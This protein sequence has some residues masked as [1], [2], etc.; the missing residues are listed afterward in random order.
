MTKVKKATPKNA[1]KIEAPEV[2]SERASRVAATL[3]RPSILGAVTIQ[4]LSKSYG[5]VD[6]M[7]LVESL[8]EQSKAVKDGNLGRAEAMLMTQAHTLD[9][10]FNNLAQR[11]ALNM[12]EYINAADRYMRLA[13]KA[14]SQCRATIEALGELKNPQPVAFV[15]QANFA[16]GPQQVNNGDNFAT[17]THARAE[18]NQNQPNELLEDIPNEQLD[19][20]TPSATS[21]ADTAVETLGKIDGAANCRRKNRVI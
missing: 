10:I 3:L 11:A 19:S 17:S 12:G 15:K 4:S 6:L 14:Q 7:A 20:R 13:L 8:A 2:E 9:A 5:E 21:R 1:L 18:K 16:N